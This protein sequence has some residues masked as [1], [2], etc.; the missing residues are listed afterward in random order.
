MNVIRT[1]EEPNREL[2]L[3]ESIAGT[4]NTAQINQRHDEFGETTDGE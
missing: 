4:R 3:G 1:V 2:I